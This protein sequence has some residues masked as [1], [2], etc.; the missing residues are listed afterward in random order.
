MYKQLFMIQQ[1][2]ERSNLTLHKVEYEDI[3]T[4]LLTFSAICSI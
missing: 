4:S 2:E 1:Q 3:V